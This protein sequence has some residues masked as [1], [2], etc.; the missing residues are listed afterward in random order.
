MSVQGI[1]AELDGEVIGVAGVAY[2]KPMQWF[3]VIRDELKRHPRCMVKAM[4]QMRVLLDDLDVPV[5]A[6][7]DEDED[8]AH[9]FL[10]HVGFIEIDKGVYQWLQPS[11][12][13]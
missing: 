12:S 3:S 10:T 7:S 6:T 4:R 9:E 11:H 2:S 13:Y 5:F 1:A 8:T